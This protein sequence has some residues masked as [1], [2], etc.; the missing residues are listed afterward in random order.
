MPI[1][2]L[3][4]FKAHKERSYKEYDDSSTAFH[5][6]IKYLALVFLMCSQSLNNLK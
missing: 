5:I 1:R 2:K 6:H 4:G 3:A